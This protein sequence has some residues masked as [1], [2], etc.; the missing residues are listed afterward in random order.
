MVLQHRTVA[1]L[2][3]MASVLDTHEP[4]PDSAKVELAPIQHWYFAQNLPAVAHWNLSI[5]LELQARM[6][7]QLLQQALN[8]LVKLHPALRL[9]FEQVD[10]VWQQHYSAAA[11][12]P[13][14]LLPAS[15]QQAAVRE[16]ELQSLLNLS[17]GPLVRAAY[18]DAGETNQPEL[19]L[20]AHHL[21]MDTWSLRIL[22]EDLASI[23]TS[24]HSGTPIRVL[25]E[26]TSYR[27]W[28]QWL[29]QHATDFTSQIPYWRNMLD[30]GTPPAAMPR[31]GC[32]G[33]RQVIFAE[34]DRETSDLLT[35]DAHQVYHSRGQELLL[36][37]LAQAWH[38]WCGNAHLA[39]ELETHG[40]EAFQDA[41]MDL[42]R[43]VGWFTALFPLRIATGSGWADTVD[44]V[45]QTLRHIPS[46]GHGYG[47]LRYLQ[48]TPDLC[49]PAPPSIS[50]N[51]LG[52]TA[53]SASSA[54]AIRLSRR[55]AGPG[56]AAYQLLPH[57]L[58]VTVMLVAGRL[59]F[60]LAYADTAADAAMQT[61]LNH[62]QHALHD[63][64]EHCR[65]AEPVDLQSSDVSGVQLSDS[66][67]SA[68]LSDL[69]EDDQ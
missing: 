26:G 37:A 45:K 50:F 10:G 30:A 34:L 56:Q 13:L 58:N 35:G 57:A 20:I 51:Y 6:T 36:T 23:Y 48:Q 25:Q 41:A 2:A 11:A 49:E 59:R 67:L 62:Y 64:A 66:E 31:K 5:R 52:D 60:S 65:L 29:S 16:A 27:Q 43:S 12:I 54:M 33:D 4:E 32:V 22:T 47:V 21:I 1:A 24:L 14:E 44:N 7:P 9:R 68:I 61:L 15:H 3:A 55:E 53:M 38:R 69:T 17:T 42:S 40:R 18:R 39:I 8:E 46:G 19:V 63:L 28:S